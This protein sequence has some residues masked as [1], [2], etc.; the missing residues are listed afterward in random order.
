MIAFNVGL[1][2]LGLLGGAVV[3][4]GLAHT[5]RQRAARTAALVAEGE[6]VSATVLGVATEGAHL[7]WRRVR[8]RCS[9]GRELD[10]RLDS[11]RADRLGLQVGERRVVLRS[12]RPDANECR[13]VDALDADSSSITVAVVAGA[14]IAALGV[15]AAF[16]L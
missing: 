1:A 8:V 9:D 11:V 2:V 6:R 3:A 5:A 14:V 12:R 13:L 16:A 4:G 15:A 7:Q 10:D